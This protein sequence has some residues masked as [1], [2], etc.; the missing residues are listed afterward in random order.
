MSSREELYKKAESDRATRCG[1][2][3]D[4]QQ[5]KYGYSRD[6]SGTMYCWKVDNQYKEENELLKFKDWDMN[7]QKSS[8]VH[9]ERGYV[10]VIY[11]NK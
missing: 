6:M 11:E 3:V 5:R 7:V 10:Y 9:G 2:T 4:P 8:N 1:A